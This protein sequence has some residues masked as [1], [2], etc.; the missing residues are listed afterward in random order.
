MYQLYENPFA[1]I[2]LR[3]VLRVKVKSLGRNILVMLDLSA[4]ESRDTN[5][6]AVIHIL[7]KP[8]LCQ[9]SNSSYK[10]DLD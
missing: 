5:L 7:K 3:S 10:S 2:T 4:R 6:T 8:G 1:C 9:R